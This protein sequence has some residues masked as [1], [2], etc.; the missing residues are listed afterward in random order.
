VILR[1][2]RR[3]LERMAAA[4]SV[5]ARTLA[6]LRERARPGVTT[7]ELDRAA[8]EFI[9]GQGGVPTFKGYHGF[10]ASICV[11]PNDMVVHGIPGAYALREGDVLSVDVGV[12][13]RG[14]VADSGYTFWIGEGDPPENVLRLLTACRASLFAA[15]EQCVDGGHLSDLGHAVQTRV[16]ADG[17]GVIR[18][19][20]GHGVGRRM[21]EDPQIPNYG[22]P[23]RGHV[24]RPGMTLAVEPMITASGETDVQL[25]EDDGWSIYSADHSLTAH[26][27]HTVAVT[28][29]G[30]LILTRH[31]GWSPVDDEVGS[32]A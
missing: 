3:E 2:S 13:L 1:K 21:H 7:G 30:P 20:V 4:G 32:T 17:F 10:P 27:E 6:L 5:V 15:L 31:E 12:T 23:G 24:L 9:R 8:E 18:S 19:L 28:D 11:S 16:E 22:P 25:D 29:D 26:Y 14:W